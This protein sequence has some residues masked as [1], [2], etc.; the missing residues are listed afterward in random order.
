MSDSSGEQSILTDPFSGAVDA[1]EILKHELLRSKNP[2]Y[3]HIVATGTSTRSRPPSEI[4]PSSTPEP[5]TY[6][7]T[8]QQKAS[9]VE[10]YGR[11]G[12][13]FDLL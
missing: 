3:G 5:E 7:P 2:M 6:Q 12:C 8:Q 4:E 11:A 13:P 10:E 9:P 1:H